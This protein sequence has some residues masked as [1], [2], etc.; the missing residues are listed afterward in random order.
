MAESLSGS[1][2]KRVVAWGSVVQNK[3]QPNTKMSW[4]TIRSST[5]FGESPSL[6]QRVV[7]RSGEGVA[8]EVKRVEEIALPGAI[9]S[10]QIRQRTKFDVAATDAS[11]VSEH[12]ALE[13]NRSA[14]LVGL[15]GSDVAENAS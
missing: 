11:V 12:D 6:V 3:F 1:N 14:H 13:E 7:E 4:V 10:D 15:S 2:F 8:D 9:G 5:Y